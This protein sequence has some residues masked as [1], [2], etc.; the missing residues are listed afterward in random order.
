MT[1]YRREDVTAEERAVTRSMVERL[2]GMLA[3]EP[4]Q[5][6][7]GH[8]SPEVHQQVGA[9]WADWDRQRRAWCALLAPR[10]LAEAMDDV[11]GGPDARAY[12]TR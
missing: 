9:A 10:L 3:D 6:A 2:I 4:A 12:D 1:G 7:G 5:D 8:P 11:R